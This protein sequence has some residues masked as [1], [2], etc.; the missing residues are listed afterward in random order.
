MKHQYGPLNSMLG[1]VFPVERTF[2]VKPQAKIRPPYTQVRQ[3]DRQS[4]DSDLPLDTETVTWVSIDSMGDITTSRMVDSA[5]EC[6]DEP[7][8]IVV[9][10][11]PEYGSDRPLAIV[12]VKKDH[13][14]MSQSSTLHSSTHSH[15]LHEHSMSTWCEVHEESM[16]SMAVFPTVYMETIET[17]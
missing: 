16:D 5:R 2:M 6:V 15:G 11:G 4:D 13:Q 9:K 12:E 7:D 14:T 3:P 17:F 8:F 1:H 10:S